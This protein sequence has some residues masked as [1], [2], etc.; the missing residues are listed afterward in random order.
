[1]IFDASALRKDTDADGFPYKESGVT[2]LR[3]E[4]STGIVSSDHTVTGK[5]RMVTDHQPG[6]LLLAAWTGQYRTDLFTVT[7]ERAALALGVTIPGACEG[8]TPS[9]VPTPL[10]D[11]TDMELVC[12]DSGA[13]CGIVGKST[14][15]GTW[16]AVRWHKGGGSSGG[17]GGTLTATKE[18]VRQRVLEGGPLDAAPQ[19]THVFLTEAQRKE[20]RARGRA[21]K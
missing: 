13:V 7:H 2:F 12:D 10:G 5:R 8:D 19:W 14:S 1:M 17:G 16:Q 18:A 3:I 4:H 6:D 15:R 20:L 9:V 21:R 11:L